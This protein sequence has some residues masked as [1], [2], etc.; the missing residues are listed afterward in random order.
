MCG[1]LPSK[2]GDDLID[3][4]AK[5]IKKAVPSEKNQQLLQQAL[6]ARPHMAR[7]ESLRWRKSSPL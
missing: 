2:L 6:R 7:L 1:V 3:E 5:T 4:L